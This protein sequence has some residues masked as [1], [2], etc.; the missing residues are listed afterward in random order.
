VRIAFL[1]GAKQQALHNARFVF[2][3]S[4]INPAKELPLAGFAVKN[5]IHVDK[6][7]GR[8]LCGKAVHFLRSG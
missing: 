7:L 4:F 1:F 2:K 8:F 5:Q 3:I 6:A